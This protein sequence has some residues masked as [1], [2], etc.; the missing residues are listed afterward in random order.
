M[1]QFWMWYS[2]NTNVSS[3][4][5]SAR[6]WGLQRNLLP[7]C[8]EETVESREIKRGAAIDTIGS[9]W[10]QQQDISAGL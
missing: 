2:A 8:T 4:Y 3:E 10:A 5:N 9:I 1:S 6:V 7:Y